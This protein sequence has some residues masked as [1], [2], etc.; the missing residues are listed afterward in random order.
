MLSVH[1]VD[2]YAGSL[3]LIHCS[4]YTSLF[5]HQFKQ[6]MEFPA[7]H[8]FSIAFPMICAH[9]MNATHDLCP[10][11]VCSTCC[12]DRRLVLGFRLRYLTRLSG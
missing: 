10:E 2:F 4:F 8:R 11:E 7:Q 12:N 1:F 3:F 9:F 6:C 5:E